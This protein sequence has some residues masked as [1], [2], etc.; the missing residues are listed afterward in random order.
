MFVCSSLLYLALL[1]L[2][3][4]ECNAEVHLNLCVSLVGFMAKSKPSVIKRGPHHNAGMKGGHMH[5][6]FASLKGQWHLWY[7]MKT[8]AAGRGVLI[9]IC[10]LLTVAVGK[11]E[12]TRG[13]PVPFGQSPLRNVQHVGN[14]MSMFGSFSVI[15]YLAIPPCQQ[16]CGLSHSFLLQLAMFNLTKLFNVSFSLCHLCSLSRGERIQ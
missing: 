6:I 3:A 13:K 16:I 14:F 9:S 12:P 7:E 8:P 15:L 10:T 11:K 5:K 2:A 1:C 4:A